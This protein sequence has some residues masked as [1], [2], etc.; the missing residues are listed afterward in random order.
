MDLLLPSPRASVP[1]LLCSAQTFLS[2]HRPRAHSALGPEQRPTQQHFSSG[3][4]VLGLCGGS[5]GP[6]LKSNIM[7]WDI[8]SKH[9]AGHHKNTQW[10]L[11]HG[12]AG[13]TLFTMHARSEPM[14]NAEKKSVLKEPKGEPKMSY[15]ER[16]GNRVLMSHLAS[17][18]LAAVWNVLLLEL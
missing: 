18:P 13:F 15:V 6:L 2:L 8:I 12:A 1:P 9:P 7:N 4:S 11:G 16:C 3:A 5:P 14:P 17:V 10:T